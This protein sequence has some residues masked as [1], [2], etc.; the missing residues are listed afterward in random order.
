MRILR[1]EVN[2]YLLYHTPLCMTPPSMLVLCTL[3]LSLMPEPTTSIYC[4]GGTYLQAGTSTCTDCLAVTYAV[5]GSMRVYCSSFITAALTCIDCLAGTYSNARALTC[6]DCLANT[7]SLS[8]SSTCTYCLPGKFSGSIATACINC[9]VGK[10]N[11]SS[12]TLLVASELIGL[13]SSI[14]R[15]TLE[16]WNASGVSEWKMGSVGLSCSTCAVNPGWS[17]RHCTSR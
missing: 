12:L 6:N 10:Y 9:V 17:V 3:L 11:D 5:P 16:A 1:G 13:S 14:S 8:G 15:S 2:S 4:Y 7:Y